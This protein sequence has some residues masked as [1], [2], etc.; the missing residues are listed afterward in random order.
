MITLSDALIAQLR[1]VRELT[2]QDPPTSDSDY[3]QLANALGLAFEL[4]RADQD[5]DQ[6]HYHKLRNEIA[7]GEWAIDGVCDELARELEDGQS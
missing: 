1:F 4:T 3:D 7:G 6:V 2:G 5:R